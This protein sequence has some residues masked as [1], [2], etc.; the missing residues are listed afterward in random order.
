[1]S[2]VVVDAVGGG[3]H[4]ARVEEGA[5]AQAEAGRGRA[6]L[7]EGD[8]LADAVDRVVRIDDD[9]R[10]RIDRAVVGRRWCRAARWAG[11]GGTV[12]LVTFP[13]GTRLFDGVL[14]ASISEKSYSFFKTE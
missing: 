11:P 3:D 9:R 14:T 12:W 5:G 8:L 2:R 7:D 10:V 1:M 13:A 4:R 6:G